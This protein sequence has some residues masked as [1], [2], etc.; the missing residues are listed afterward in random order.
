MFGTILEYLSQTKP[1]DILVAIEEKEQK[2]E[3]E[4]KA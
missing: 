3:W 1:R 2:R 4:R